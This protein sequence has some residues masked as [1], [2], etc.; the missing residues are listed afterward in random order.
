[1]LIKKFQ[2]ENMPEALKMVKAEFGLDAMILNS[3]EERRKGLMGFF[4][5][6]Y[7]EVTAAINKG[8]AGRAT[9]E[10]KQAAEPATTRDEFRNAMLE[11]LAR[12][13]RQLREKVDILFEKGPDD[14]KTAHHLPDNCR[15][16]PAGT[17]RA[18][19]AGIDMPEEF[20][21][22]QWRNGAAGD[23]LPSQAPDLARQSGGN[24]PAKTKQTALGVFAEGLRQNGI[25]TEIVGTLLEKTVSF[26]GRKRKQADIGKGLEQA[27]ESLVDFGGG[28]ES[29]ND[30]QRVIALVGPTGVGKTTTI[31][32]MALNAAGQGK[33]VAILTADKLKPGDVEH[34]K[35]C[36]GSAD[37]LIDSA[38][39]PQ[40][41]G[42]AI[43]NHRERDVVLIDTSGISPND[44]EG[45]EH[46][47]KLLTTSP[48]IEK[49]LCL[50]STTRD[51]E[52][53]ETVKRFARYAIDR[54]VFTR[55]DESATFGSIINVLLQS[56]LPPSFLTNGQKVHGNIEI[57]TA[58]RLAKLAV[59]GRE[60]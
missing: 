44:R 19:A 24:M 8:A 37:I 58:G 13:I 29:G 41:L 10:T 5:K 7:V 3:R 45:M 32:K 50:S 48:L 38:T 40:K 54:L 59:G 6:P 25:D 33:K 46:L 47:E 36:A 9:P 43:K 21:K 56:N 39:T 31:A 53:A 26:I 27:L 16:E 28:E 23:D 15:P 22:V 42:R 1:M 34:L 35:R 30:G 12:E 11:P 20:E 17:P 49:H 2:A 60:S 55:L 18:E 52:L 4:R 14:M 57:A 51:R